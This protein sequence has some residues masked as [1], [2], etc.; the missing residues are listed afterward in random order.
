MGH[1]VQ[2]PAVIA[3]RNQLNW[4]WMRDTIQA[5]ET[6]PIQGVANLD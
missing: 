5:A 2:Y 1:E 6:T 3:A 4:Q